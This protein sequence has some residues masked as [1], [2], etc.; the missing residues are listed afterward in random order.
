M[1]T[2]SAEGPKTIMAWLFIM[3]R[4]DV[5]FTLDGTTRKAAIGIAHGGPA[6]VKPD[7]VILW[8]CGGTAPEFIFGADVIG[9]DTTNDKVNYSLEWNAA[10]VNGETVV[11]RMICV[12]RRSE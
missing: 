4:N 10:G 1:I 12:F 7:S 6:G 2:A 3:T 5:T 11:V 9:Y 8:H